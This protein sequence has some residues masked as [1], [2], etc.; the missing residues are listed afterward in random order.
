VEGT[1]LGLGAVL[2]VMFIAQTVHPPL[3]DLLA[4]KG[5]LVA[6]RPWT[7]LSSMFIHSSGEHLLHN[8]FPLILFGFI[9]ERIAGTRRFITIL[10]IAELASSI[11]VMQAYPH[12]RVLGAS[13]AARGVV[14][15][16]AA[17]RP[18]LIVYWGAPLPVIVLGGIWLA[19]DT[20]GVY[21]H[22]ENIAYEGHLGGLLA[23]FFLGLAWR[24]HVRPFGREEDGPIPEVDEKTAEKWED[25]YILS[26]HDRER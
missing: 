10:L 26:E 4:F 24:K 5:E 6:Q 8:L 14:G 20:A 21:G 16:I 13:G 22:A 18:T 2:V 15:A 19:L 9:L 7:L 3:T 23:G 11:A 17:M 25:K 1:F 12:V